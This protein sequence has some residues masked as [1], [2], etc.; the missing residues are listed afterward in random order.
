[1]DADVTV[2]PPSASTTTDAD[3]TTTSSSADTTMT[4]YGAPTPPS[5]ITTMDTDGPALKQPQVHQPG[6]LSNQSYLT[7]MKQQ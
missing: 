4:A 2:T 5:A 7:Q 1:M 3:G 6:Q